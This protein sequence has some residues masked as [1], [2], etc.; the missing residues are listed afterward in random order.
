MLT[1]TKPKTNYFQ[2][3][4]NQLAA[5][6]SK[7]IGNGLIER[8]AS[9]IERI[10]YWLDNDQAGYVTSDGHKWI[11]NSYREWVKQFSWLKPHQIG[12]IMRKLEAIG[13][14][15]TSRYSDLMRIG[16]RG[17]SPRMHPDDRSKF[18]RINWD[19]LRPPKSEPNIDQT[20]KPSPC[21]NVH[22]CTMHSTDLYDDLQ[23]SPNLEINN[24]VVVNNESGYS[25]R[26]V[27]DMEEF[28]KS[29][30][31]FKQS[32]ETAAVESI[33]IEEKKDPAPQA[34]PTL[35]EAEENGVRLTPS[36]MKLMGQV[37][38]DVVKNAIDALK[39]ARR[40][41]SVKNPTG[42]LTEALKNQWRPNSD[43][44]ALATAELETFNRW[45]PIARKKGIAIA[46]QQDGDRIMVFTSDGDYIP[47]SEMLEKY[48]LT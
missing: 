11:V 7:L 5:D 2:R 47:F 27:S 40:R 36:I 4:S 15:I 43:E 34:N 32:E 1:P 29:I 37:A 38:A 8:A 45:F 18:Y 35:K 41:G 9:V 13:V 25:D 24:N 17:R 21:A 6:L 31:K 19:V 16:F 30:A 22:K 3:F 48:P 44:P 46:S 33:V 39:E 23:R 28:A 10:A 14:L 42:Y 26:K 20:L 12:Y